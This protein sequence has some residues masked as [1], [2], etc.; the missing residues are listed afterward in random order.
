MLDVS[1]TDS[2]FSLPM[3][4]VLVVCAVPCRY[5]TEQLRRA[6]CGQ[7]SVVF[8]EAEEQ[9]LWGLRP[10]VSFVFFTSHTPC[11]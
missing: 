9:G 8:C 11:E 4:M 6:V 3:V 7:G 10:G 1:T 5:L 2:D